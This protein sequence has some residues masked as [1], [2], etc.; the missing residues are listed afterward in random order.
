MSRED[1]TIKEFCARIAAIEKVEVR[2]LER[3]DRD[4]PGQGGCDA[5]IER[6]GKKFAVE[7]T[8]IDSFAGQRADS[9]RFK[10]VVV[11]LEKVIRESY[12]D[13]W[14]EIAVPVE[15]VPTGTDWP[16][17]SKALQRECLKIIPQIPFE[18]KSQEYHLDG[19]PFSVWITRRRAEKSPACYVMRVA[20][21]DQKKQLGKNMA[22]AIRE[23]SKQLA[24]YRKDGLP[25]ILLLDSDDF[26]L[27]NPQSLADA[28]G[29]AAKQET[30]T[31]LDE[32]YIA[33][34]DQDPIWFY[35]V[36]F[37]EK[38]YPDLNEFRSYFR[39]QYNLISR[40]E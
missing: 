27:V 18:D 4:N 30:V 25:T 24:I 37:Y 17:L 22:K 35:P 31:G 38:L 28:F 19:I 33:E 9:A 1:K 29:E 23:K 13:S 12:P 5:I 15:A 26:V 7:H 34:A 36:K 16:K 32:V 11:P 39:A 6:G 2:I 20:P 40:H 3:P 8:T 10:K 14:I 21:A